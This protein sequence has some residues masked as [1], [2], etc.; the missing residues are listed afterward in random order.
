MAKASS[1]AKS[2][3]PA[4]DALTP[5][6][7]AASSGDTKAARA[8]LASLPPELPDALKSEALELRGRLAVDPAALGVAAAVLAIIAFA[9]AVALFARHG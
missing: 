2:K 8:A 9:A 3:K 6:R 4:E 7:Q 1:E 5:A